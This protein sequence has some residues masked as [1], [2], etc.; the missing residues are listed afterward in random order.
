MWPL[1]PPFHPT[2]CCSQALLALS[3]PFGLRTCVVLPVFLPHQVPPSPSSL[4]W[5]P[6]PSRLTSDVS[7]PRKPSL[8]PYLAGSH[9]SMPLG[10]LLPGLCDCWPHWT[11]HPLRAAGTSPSQARRRCFM[12][13]VCVYL[14][15]L[16]T[17]AA[18]SSGRVCC[19]CDAHPVLCLCAEA[20]PSPPVTY[21]L[22][23]PT[24]GMLCLFTRLS[25]CKNTL[26]HLESSPHSL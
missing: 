22:P 19:I 7:S 24:H 17:R 3:P 15:T 26:F 12:L 16:L 4:A 6:L 1:P 25:I 21:S 13:V 20:V 23:T 10:L 8:T 14:L 9:S 18:S 11:V 2:P 5:L